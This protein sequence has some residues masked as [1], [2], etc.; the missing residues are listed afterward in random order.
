VQF[1]TVTKFSSYPVDEDNIGYDSYSV[2]VIIKRHIPD[3]LPIR[4][5][6]VKLTYPGIPAFCNRCWRIGHAHWDCQRNKS[7]WL[8]FVEDFYNNREVTDEMLGS[9]VEA[10]KKYLPTQGGSRKQKTNHLQSNVPKQKVKSKVVVPPPQE[11]KTPPRL[12]QAAKQSS[13]NRNR[14]QD[15][16]NSQRKPTQQS[17]RGQGGNKN[18]NNTKNTN[19]ARRRVNN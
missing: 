12:K 8:E 3:V 19:Q 15:Q 7:N 4:G 1:L 5:K 18:K 17:G 11:P 13:E 10:V 6:R 14:G 2:D 9:W 16:G